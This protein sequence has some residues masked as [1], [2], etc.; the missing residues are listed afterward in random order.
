MTWG[1]ILPPPQDPDKCFSHNGSLIGIILGLAIVFGQFIAFAPQLYSIISKKHVEG[2]NLATYLLGTVSCTA[3][4]LSGLIESWNNLFCCAVIVRPRAPPRFTLLAPTLRSSN[5][6][7]RLLLSQLNRVGPVQSSWHCMISIIP[8]LQVAV[9]WLNYFMIFCLL[10]TYVKNTPEKPTAK[11]N[12]RLSL[13][14]YILWGVIGGTLITFTFILQ[15][16][17]PEIAPYT[18]GIYNK[19]LGLL[20]T[21]SI[22]LQWSPQIVTTFLHKGPGALSPITLSINAPGSM[23]TALSLILAKKSF[24]LW[25]PYVLSGAQQFVIV[26]IIAW[27]HFCGKRDHKPIEE[28]LDGDAFQGPALLLEEKEE[29]N[30]TDDDDNN[31]LTLGPS[32]PRMMSDIEFGRTDSSAANSSYYDESEEDGEEYD[33]D[34]SDP[35]VRLLRARRKRSL[36]RRANGAPQTGDFDTVSSSVPGYQTLT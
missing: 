33:D 9:N 26:S 23:V 31:M 36:S 2:I 6:P 7:K 19:T 16:G 15:G 32:E 34:G 12:F 3:V 30:R 29:H 11:R 18:T 28:L 35:Q 14:V 10:A 4:F 20:G 17:T 22:I 8:F 25:L 5:A 13:V 27:F 24:S 21:I 1:I